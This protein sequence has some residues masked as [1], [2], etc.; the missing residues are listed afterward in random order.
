MVINGL[1]V[2]NNKDFSSCQGEIIKNRLSYTRKVMLPQLN[3][4]YLAENTWSHLSR[5]V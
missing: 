5:I 1:I 2:F 4:V 3:T